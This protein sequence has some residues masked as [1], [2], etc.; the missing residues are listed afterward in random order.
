MMIGVFRKAGDIPNIIPNE[1]ELEYF[2]YTPTD[3]E[4]IAAKEKVVQCIEGAATSSGCKVI[5]GTLP[6]LL[7]N[8]R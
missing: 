1:S 4:L 8:D 5:N 3:E 2:I 7:Q 6:Q